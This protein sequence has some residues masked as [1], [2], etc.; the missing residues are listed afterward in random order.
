MTQIDLHNLDDLA[1]F[2]HA[3]EA[4]SFS[5]AARTL[6]LDPKMVS[7]R[8]ARLEAALGVRLFIRNTRH[9]AITDEG[10]QALVH[11]RTALAAIA[12]IGQSLAGDTLSG[13]I[14]VAAP[15]P[16]GRKYLAAAMAEFAARHP[17]VGF[18][19]SLSDQ[20]ADLYGGHFDL[21]LRIGEL[22]D[23]RL[24]A[25]PLA[26]NRRVL[27]AAP[28]YLKTHGAP[29]TPDELP[30]HRCLIFAYP[31]L[32]HDQWALQHA[33]GRQCSVRVTSPFSSD[34]GEVLHAWSRAGLGIALRETWD[35]HAALAA[36]ALVR[37]LPDWQALPGHI[38]LVRPQRHPPTR[39]VAA[40]MDFLCE[41][42][43]DAPWDT[44]V[45]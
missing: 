40:F 30:A 37:V 3:A 39:R 5:A 43:R 10:R 14:R 31:G 27:V 8:I 41:K 32:R 36:G 29:Q 22:P 2:V 26:V 15:A 20:V 21:A 13:P 9:L 25:R 33:D 24:V 28:G 1:V 11:A 23:S 45:Q 4:E 12:E 19:L 35:V 34:S 7:K 42:W 18:D 38:H 17:A 44:T 16:F 6:H